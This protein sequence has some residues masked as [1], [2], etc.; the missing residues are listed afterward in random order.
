MNYMY[1]HN[2]MNN[3]HNIMK[4]HHNIYSFWLGS[5]TTDPRAD[6]FEGQTKLQLSEKPLYN[7]SVINLHIF[8]KIGLSINLNYF[9]SNIH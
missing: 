3:H 2:I 9:H 8:F 7:C 5:R 4:Y 1:D 6:P